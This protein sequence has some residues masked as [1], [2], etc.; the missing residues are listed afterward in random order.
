MTVFSALRTLRQEDRKLKPGLCLKESKTKPGKVAHPCKYQNS[1]GGG[2][3]I[4]TSSRPAWIYTEFQ[5]SNLPAILSLCVGQRWLG[6]GHTQ[7]CYSFTSRLSA[8][9]L[10]GRQWTRGA[11][12][13]RLWGSPPDALRGHSPCA[14]GLQA[15]LSPL[16]LP[17]L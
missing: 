16:A 17:W 7:R 15:L 14:P 2:G 3:R 11:G 5:A 1:E 4:A 12:A 9:S 13:L 8:F 6:Q 10:Q